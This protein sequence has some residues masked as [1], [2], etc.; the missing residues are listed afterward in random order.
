MFEELFETSSK[1]TIK[2]IILNECMA[3]KEFF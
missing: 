2:P 3:G 1:D